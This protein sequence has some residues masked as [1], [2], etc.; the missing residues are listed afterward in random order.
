MKIKG[1]TDTGIKVTEF[2][3]GLDEAI[4]AKV[5]EGVGHVKARIDE[6]DKVIKDNMAGTEYVT[7]LQADVKEIK[8]KFGE[9]DGSLKA[10]NELL[11]ESRA[12]KGKVLPDE[13]E[14]IKKSIIASISDEKLTAKQREVK[15]NF[16]NATTAGE[17]GNLVQT[18]VA[19]AIMS[20]QMAYS[21]AM[22]EAR[23]EPMAT[24]QGVLKVPLDLEGASV[25]YPGEG[26]A[27]NASESVFGVA[28]LT[29]YRR[30]SKL[31]AT[32][33]LLDKGAIDI[34]N[35]FAD[36]HGIAF[37]ND[38]DKQA[39]AGTGTPMTGLRAG[40]TLIPKVI[41]AASFAATG[42]EIKAGIGLL[43]NVA[44][45]NLK[46]YMSHSLYWTYMATIATPVTTSGSLIPYPGIGDAASIAAKQIM[47]FPVRF[48]RNDA[49]YA[50]GD[51]AVS[52]I[53][54]ILADLKR[55]LILSNFGATNFAVSTE[56]TVKD[57]AGTDVNAWDQGL[58]LTKMEG[59]FT[60]YCPDFYTTL[61]KAAGV[62]FTSA[63]G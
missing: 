5:T 24:G 51:T 12:Q 8:D 9:I 27:A 35:F 11:S 44:L 30:I 37:A 14:E 13:A 49:M 6:L 46:F 28:T 63:A 53:F 59:Y 55:S 61:T 57:S 23:I 15:A 3:Q 60:G 1:I 43:D 26:T 33:E 38:T 36:S 31:I 7:K 10:H 20:I 17:G 39:F 58:I 2:E 19:R 16:N 41:A 45:D 40:A 54:A 21:V 29:P 32:R 56:A 48:T 4:D 50:S 47:G 42:A 62:S 52:L 34:L 25:S 22:Q 18:T